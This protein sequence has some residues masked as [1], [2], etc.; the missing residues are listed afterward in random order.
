MALPTGLA[1][2][3]TLYSDKGRSIRP[4]IGPAGW[5]CSVLVAADGSQVVSVFPPGQSAQGPMLVEAS[6]VPACVGCM[7]DAVCPLI[8]YADRIFGTGYGGCP[9]GR[10]PGE[11]VTWLAGPRAYA[12]HGLDVVGFTDPPGVHGYGAASGGAYPATGVL[13]FT[14]GNA[15]SYGVSEMSCTVAPTYEA[16]CKEILTLFQREVQR[17]VQREGQAG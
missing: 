5:G 4:V 1:G 13:L 10:V 14:W 7:Y 12:T 17:E 2:K 3:V 8:P 9:A 16:S 6:S 15:R 11:V